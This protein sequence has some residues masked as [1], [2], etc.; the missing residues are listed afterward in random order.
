MKWNKTT[1]DTWQARTPDDT[2]WVIVRREGAYDLTIGGSTIKRYP[3][4]NEAKAHVDIVQKLSAN[5]P[6][7]TPRPLSGAAAQAKANAGKAGAK[8]KPEARPC[9]CGCGEQTKGGTFVAGHDARYKSALIREAIAGND[10]AV[11]TLEARGWTRFLDKARETSARRVERAT[12]EGAVRQKIERIGTEQEQAAAAL[13]RLDMLKRA[14][15]VLIAM[16]RYGK[17]SGERR[18]EMGGQEI[19]GVQIPPAEVAASILDG[20]HPAFDQQDRALAQR[21]AREAS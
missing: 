1:D 2:L 6:A 13:A 15:V 3:K 8:P 18:I 21:L 4:L 20:T 5:R 12:T 19:D 7:P 16:G 14:R 9:L 11:A 10:E 17:A